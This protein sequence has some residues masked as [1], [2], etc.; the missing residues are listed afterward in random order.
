M[1]PVKAGG[2]HTVLNFTGGYQDSMNCAWR[3]ECTAGRALDTTS[4]PG[5]EL[6]TTSEGTSEPG[7]EL[8]GTSEPA[9]SDLSKEKTEQR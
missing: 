1:L 8:E 3:V 6:D 5:G 9:E 2:A 4:D 7:D